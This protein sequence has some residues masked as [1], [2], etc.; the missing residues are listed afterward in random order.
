MTFRRDLFE[1]F[2][3]NVDGAVYFAHKSKLKPSGLGTIR[4]KLPIL[5]DHLLHEVLYSLS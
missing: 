5:P 1:E 4:L 3:G 2:T